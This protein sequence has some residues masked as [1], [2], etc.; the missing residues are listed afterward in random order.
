LKKPVNRVITKAMKKRVSFCCTLLLAFLL[1]ISGCRRND[2]KIDIPDIQTIYGDITYLDSLVRSS[3]ADSISKIDLQ[4]A[5]ALSAFAN[6]AQSPEDKAILDS[7]ARIH[8][9]TQD[10]LQ[11]CTSTLINLDL[12][13]QD[14]RTLEDQ[15]RSGK[16]KITSYM[17]SLMEEE[18]L[19]IDLTNQLAEK[20]QLA[21]QYLQH[22]TLLIEKLTSPTIPGY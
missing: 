17:S 20:N 19:L 9:V 21:L 6:R 11:F 2:R 13:Q 18:Q 12:L 15:Y 5:A 10:F 1:L 14:T 22:Q 16:I 8:Q 7:L 3:Q 4:I